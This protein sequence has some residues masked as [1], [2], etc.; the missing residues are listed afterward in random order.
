LSLKKNIIAN[1]ASQ[2]YATAIGIVM[3]PLYVRHM[4][5]EAYGLIGFFSMLQVWFQLLDLGLTPTLSR[6]TARFRG[7][8]TSPLALRQLLRSLEYIF[9]CIA[10]LGC[11][12]L[13]AFAQ[14]IST[15]WLNANA[16][17]MD[18]IRHS[19]QLMAVT[20]GLRWMCSLYRGAITGFEHLVWL[21]GFSMVM[22]TL[23]FVIVVP[24]FAVIG[25]TPSIFFSYQLVVAVIELISLLLAT[26][27]L[28]PTIES[29]DSV[30]WNLVAVKAVLK[31]SASLAFTSSIWI[32]ITQLDKL[33]LSKLLPLTDYA[34]FTLAVLVA[35]GVTILSGPVSN[36]LLPRLTKL[37][38]EGNDVQLQTLY[39]QAS[40]LVACIAIPLSFTLAFF[41][42][43]VLWAWTGDATITAH[44]AVVLAVYALGNGVFS[45]GAFPYYLQ[46]A[47]GD[48]SLHVVGNVLMLLFLIP[49]LI[50]ASRKFGSVG[51]AY[52]WLAVNTAYVAT[53]APVVHRRFFH[54][55]HSQWIWRLLKST[56]FPLVSVALF[57]YY[58]VWP[59]DRWMTLLLLSLIAGT[60]LLV[61][62]STSPMLRSMSCEF[63]KRHLGTNK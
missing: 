47:K 14:P 52:T 46:Y 5:T 44:A 24:L 23:R 10:L 54:A 30:S 6:E 48:L 7:Q 40:E 53:W 41:S 8:A 2:L 32:F 17:P 19:V 26:Y 37:S 51:A 31:F 9:V 27:R 13:I 34:Y 62:V 50:W 45:L 4:G 3:V 20:I 16:L 35:S 58:V 56:C 25:S 57:S 38:S 21:A 55:L 59:Q 29:G 18:E 49:G 63:F 15:H 33:L 28:L 36:A 43:Q 22:A 1:L 42:K 12:V 61:S 60:T 39:V 11:A